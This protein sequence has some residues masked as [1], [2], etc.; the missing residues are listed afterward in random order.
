M[1]VDSITREELGHTFFM[2]NINVTSL[3]RRVV[4]QQAGITVKI[5]LPSARKPGAEFTKLS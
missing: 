1:K 2:V 3:C 5:F 4:R